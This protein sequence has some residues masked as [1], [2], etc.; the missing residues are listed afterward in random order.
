MKF[1]NTYGKI[2]TF[3]PKKHSIVPAKSADMGVG[4]PRST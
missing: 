1:T 3:S 4:R 2:L